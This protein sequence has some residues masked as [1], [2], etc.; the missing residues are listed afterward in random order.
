MV[1]RK[2]CMNF[3]LCMF[4]LMF[5]MTSVG[6]QDTVHE[7]AFSNGDIYTVDTERDVVT[8]LTH[9]ERYDAS[10]TWSPDGTQIAFVETLTDDFYGQYGLYVMNAD[11]SNTIQLA[12]D[13]V[14]R[15][16]PV[17]LGNNDAILY[18]TR[19]DIQSGDCII[20]SVKRDGSEAHEIF[21]Q[22]HLN[23]N[24]AHL[25]PQLSPD[26]TQIVFGLDDN[27]SRYFQLYAMD[28]MSGQVK[29]LTHDRANHASPVWSPDGT[30]IAFVSTQ[31]GQ[32]EIYVMNAD[33]SNVRRLTHRPGD[34]YAPLWLPDGKHLIFAS[35]QKGYNIFRLDLSSGVV[36]NLTNLRESGAW[37]VALSS[38]GTQ[39]AYAS[40][41]DPV[42]GPEDIQ[43][44]TLD[45]GDTHE[46]SSVGANAYEL[47]W[48]P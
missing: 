12:D 3:A 21:R 43:V 29:Q 37:N 15:S 34:D 38:D 39:I 8:Q 18:A 48:R 22:S 24:I 9:T 35:D 5:V 7:L 6:A 20:K 36:R 47:A 33:G 46:L 42:S 16:A 17:W 2:V 10:P 45:T 13:L 40:G 11:G 27:A 41:V 31:D 32:N 14:W 28:L 1:M 19:S 30:Q 26:D 23:C 4:C 44:M 25:Y